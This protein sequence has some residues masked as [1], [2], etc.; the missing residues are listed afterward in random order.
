MIFERSGLFCC[1]FWPVYPLLSGQ[2]R[3]VVLSAP[4]CLRVVAVTWENPSRL[5]LFL[6]FVFQ[7]L[8]H[9]RESKVFVNIKRIKQYPKKQSGSNTK[10][11]KVA[12]RLKCFNWADWRETGMVRGLQLLSTGTHRV[13]RWAATQNSQATNTR[14]ST[15]GPSNSLSPQVW[16]VKTAGTMQKKLWIFQYLHRQMAIF[17]ISFPWDSMVQWKSGGRGIEAGG[18][19]PSPHP[20]VKQLEFRSLWMKTPRPESRTIKGGSKALPRPHICPS[21]SQETSLTTHAQ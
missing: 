6:A 3:W 2:F 9:L 15:R 14:A 21:L 10:G 7:K 17:H 18:K 8:E 12:L 13:V 4:H 1:V 11:E 20:R 16:R 5:Q 19:C